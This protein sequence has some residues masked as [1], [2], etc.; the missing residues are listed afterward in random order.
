MSLLLRAGAGD[1]VS[2]GDMNQ[3]EI[4]KEKDNCYK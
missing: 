1:N 2:C 3:T 4:N